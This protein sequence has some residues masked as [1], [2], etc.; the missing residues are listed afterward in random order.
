M[1]H[2]SQCTL[3]CAR[4]VYARSVGTTETGVRVGERAF[5]PSVRRNKAPVCVFEVKNTRRF[6]NGFP[7]CP[8]KNCLLMRVPET[9]DGFWTIFSPVRYIDQSDGVGFAYF[10]CRNFYPRYYYEKLKPKNWV[11]ERSWRPWK[12]LSMASYSCSW[13][14]GKR[15]SNRVL[16]WRR[17]FQSLLL[18]NL[19]CQ[20]CALF[21]E[22][23]ICGFR[24][25]L[26]PHQN[27]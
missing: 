15:T 12:F 24:W 1:A 22:S 21:P 10:H 2:L 11:Y 5:H 20:R 17:I 7:R 27:K 6:L 16:P 19:T 25:R 13:D 8:L 3:W 26:T 18:S 14:T 23:A 9:V 4:D